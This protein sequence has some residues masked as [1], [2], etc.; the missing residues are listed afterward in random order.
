MQKKQ[1]ENNHQFNLR[2]YY[3]KFWPYFCDAYEYGYCD[4]C[5]NYHIVNK[6]IDKTFLAMKRN[7]I[8][9]D[10]RTNFHNF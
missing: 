9:R 6:F 1:E 10:P 7:K 2:K 5:E 8:Q 3:K 4:L